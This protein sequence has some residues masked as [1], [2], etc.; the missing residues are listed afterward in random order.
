MGDDS[1]RAALIYQP[2]IRNADRK[3]TGTLIAHAEADRE[4]ANGKK[5]SG[6]ES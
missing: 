3:I 2:T 1:D 5:E 6:A 4:A